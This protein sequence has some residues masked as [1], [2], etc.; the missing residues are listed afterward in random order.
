M[1]PTILVFG[2]KGQL[3]RELAKLGA[4]RGLEFDFAGRAE[5]DLSGRDDPAQL[6]EARAPSA[7]INAAAYT[8]VDRAESEPDAAFRLNRDVPAAI[9]RACAAR[10]LPLVHLS[11]D[12]VFDGTKTDPYVEDD[13]V[14]PISV[15]GQ[16]KAEGEAAVLGSGGRASVLRTAWLYSAFGSNFVKTMLRAAL[17]R[18]EISVVDDQVG[19]PTWAEDSAGGALRLIEALLDRDDRALG[20]LH[21]SGAD[22]A[23]W[24]DFAEAIFEQSAHRGGPRPAVRRITTA[25][26]PTPARRPANS[27][28][29]C[30]RIASV[31][32]WRPRPSRDG[33][34]A[35]FDAL[36]PE[37]A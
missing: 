4:P 20:V 18:P 17:T 37:G 3:A 36:G 9:A 1:N 27:R 2:R 32:D 21:L 11:T 22:D 14:C 24:A 16:S 7:V 10:D 26:Y 29:D 34:A 15:Y 33:L 35:V 19:R 6:I 8:A 5:F 12:Y 23:T 28:L 30:S 25:E 13:L 31:L